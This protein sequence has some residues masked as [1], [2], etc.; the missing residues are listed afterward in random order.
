MKPK[1]IYDLPTERREFWHDCG[2]LV[3]DFFAIPQYSLDADAAAKAGANDV[4]FDQ[5]LR[6]FLDSGERTTSYTAV[7]FKGQ[8]VGMYRG[9]GRGEQDFKEAIVTDLAGYRA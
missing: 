4:T 9:G 7:L 6:C 1:D 2:S 3:E 8:P 5:K